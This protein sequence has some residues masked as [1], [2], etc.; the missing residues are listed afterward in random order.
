MRFCLSPALFAAACFTAANLFTIPCLAQSDSDRATARSLG[1]EMDRELIHYY[2][3]RRVWRLQV[4][5][6]KEPA[7][8]Q[9]VSTLE[10]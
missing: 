10:R 6:D 3:E 9:E 8:L 5:D 7:R 1:T 2:P 4:H